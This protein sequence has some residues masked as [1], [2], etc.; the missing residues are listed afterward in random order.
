MQEE[1]YDIFIVSGNVPTFPAPS[2]LGRYGNHGVYMSSDAAASMIANAKAAESLPSSFTSS[3]LSL[4]STASDFLQRT[5]VREKERKR[6]W[7]LFSSFSLL[8][9]V[10]LLCSCTT[11]KLGMQRKEDKEQLCTIAALL[12]RYIAALQ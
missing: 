9:V 3:A 8:F 10:V 1:G 6:D 7:A 4:W 11:S 12:N 2:K 5:L